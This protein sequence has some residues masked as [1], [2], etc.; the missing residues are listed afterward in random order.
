MCV[1]LLVGYV[2]FGLSI[3]DWEQPLCCNIN[4]TMIVKS[5]AN[6]QPEK[7]KHV[8]QSDFYSENRGKLVGK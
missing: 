1:R 2:Y 8:A 7:F 5:F 6:A 4:R 3:C